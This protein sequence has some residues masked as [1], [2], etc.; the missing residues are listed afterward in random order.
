MI[1]GLAPFNDTYRN[2][3]EVMFDIDAMSGGEYAGF[4]RRAILVDGAEAGACPGKSSPWPIRL[5]D[6]E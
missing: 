1:W 3:W 5:Q 4:K 2:G 6:L